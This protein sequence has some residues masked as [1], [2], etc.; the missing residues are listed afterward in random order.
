MDI[1][2]FP[3]KQIPIQEVIDLCDVALFLEN[4][5]LVFTI[6]YKLQNNISERYMPKKKDGTFY[7]A[8]FIVSFH[9][10]KTIFLNENSLRKNGLSHFSSSIRLA[11]DVI[12]SL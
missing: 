10:T 2:G 3:K 9:T 7:R 4:F 11:N 1:G 8:L 6:V 12:L 5:D